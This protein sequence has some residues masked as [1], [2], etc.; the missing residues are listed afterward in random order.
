MRTIWANLSPS[1]KEEPFD[2]ALRG[3]EVSTGQFFGFSHVC[4]MMGKVFESPST[5][6]NGGKQFTYVLEASKPST[7]LSS[8]AS[9]PNYLPCCEL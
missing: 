1:A 7:D 6:W 4:K 9:A 2:G 5:S 8:L 3:V